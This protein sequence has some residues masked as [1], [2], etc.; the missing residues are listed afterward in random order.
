[1][2]FFYKYKIRVLNCLIILLIGVSGCNKQPETNQLTSAVEA[3]D[4]LATFTVADGFKIEMIAS[5]PLITDPVD[6]EIDEYGRLY[7]VEMHGYP[8]DAKTGSGNIILLSDEDGDGNM[9]KRKV[10]AEGLTLPTSVMRWKKGI[11]VTD[12]P[13]ILYFEDTDNDGKANLKD[14]LLSGFALSNPQHNVNTPVYGL[15]NWIYVAHEGS[16]TTREYKEDFGDEGSEII[17]PGVPNSPKL[18]IN[19]N[20]RSIRFQPEQRK[21]EMSSSRTQFGHTFDEW[22]NLFGCNNSNQGYHEVI[23]NRY[24]DRNPDLLSSESTQNMSDHLNAPEVFP[25]TIH[26]DRQILTN[27]GVMTSACGITTYLG[28]SFPDP[29]NKNVTFITESV[30]NLVHVDVLK[31]NGASFTASRVL[32]NKEFLTSTDA[33][34]RPVNIYVGPDGSIYVLD[35]YRRVIESPEW[36]SEEAIKAGDL[37][38]GHDKGRIFRIS[39]KDAKNAEW[40]KGLKL[41]NESTEGLVKQLENKNYWWRINAQ[42]LLVD[43]ADKSAVPFLTELVRNSKS[44]L[45]RLHAL[46]TLEGLGELNSP[47]IQLALKDKIPGVRTN[48]IKL[49]ELHLS[50]S[51]ELAKNLLSLQNDSDA[52]VRF[53][54][55]LTLGYLNSTEAASVRNKL[56]FKDVTDKWVQIAALSAPADQTA[57]LL[58]VVLNNYRSDVPEFASLVQRLTRMVGTSGSPEDINKLIKQSTSMVMGKRNSWQGAMLEGLS[59]GLESRKLK[60]QESILAFDGNQ[61]LLVTTFFDHPTSEVR[62]AALEMLRVIELKDETLKNKSIQRAIKIATDRTLSDKARTESINFISLTDPTPHSNILKQL[63]VPQEQPIIQLAALKVLNKIPDT[64][65]SEYV[66][67]QWPVL[68]PEIRE[69]AIGTFL[70]KDNQDRIELLLTAI[71]TN[72]IQASSVSFGRSVGLMQNT[73]KTLRNR[74]RKL[75]T[76]DDEE[77]KKVNKEY[78]KALELTGDVTNGKSVF[79]QNC[80]ICH[81]VRGKIGIEFGPDMGTVHNWTREDIM[82]NILNPNLSISSGYDLW[83]VELKNGELAQGIILSE[84]STALTLR[85]NGKLDKTINRQDIKSIKSLNESAMPSGLEKKINKQEMADLLAFLRKN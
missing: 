39:P 81:Q 18:P 55:L 27:V 46:W 53:Q 65:V 74:A 62:Q 67:K 76:K 58:K 32:E 71:E 37:Y 7:V 43:R 38:D 25:T 26:P 13:H 30:S 78:K 85:N 31:E 40:T 50:K 21:L 2:T 24:F 57:P 79:I 59:H 20:G 16:V 72:K 61:S 15:D 23:P 70:G 19:A 44:P 66:I 56:L 82:A 34:S 54:L 63:I 3:K 4:A 8:L 22:G 69:A 9:D 49:A 17:F 47:L 80:A 42:R 5:E 64:T 28:D 51:P 41:G 10:F 84:T 11:I 77:G 52:K 35:Y 29:F 68:T 75:F 48:A 83:E 73:D 1:M 14:T 60:L 12:A 36:M 45:G 33:W 6:M